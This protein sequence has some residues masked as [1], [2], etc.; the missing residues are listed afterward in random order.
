MCRWIT[1]AQGGTLHKAINDLG[2]RRNSAQVHGKA[3]AADS[4]LCMRRMPVLMNSAHAPGTHGVRF[5]NQVRCGPGF[6]RIFD[7]NDALDQALAIDLQT[8]NLMRG[9]NLTVS[10]REVLARRESQPGG[11]VP[12][13]FQGEG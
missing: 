2:N 7:E 3:V 9:R 4:G 1:V 11:I 8:G 12:D 10:L 6:L 13:R 5:R